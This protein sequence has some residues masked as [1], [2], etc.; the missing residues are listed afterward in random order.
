MQIPGAAAHYLCETGYRTRVLSSPPKTRQT[1]RARIACSMNAI[2]FLLGASLAL[3]QSTSSTPAAPGVSPVYST[4]TVI[5]VHSDLVLIPVTVTDHRGKTVSGLEKENFKLFE[6]DAEQEIIHFAS[7][8]APA[9]IGI[10][11][12]TSGSMRSKMSKAVDAV[13]RLLAN[14][15]PDDEFFLVQFSTEARL[16]A[17][18]TTR[19]DDIR[20]HMNGLRTTG[21]TALLDA[22]R[23]ALTEME[24]AQHQRKAIVIISDGDDNSSSWTVPELKTAVRS[25]DTVIYA[26]GIPGLP[27]ERSECIPGH[28]C[29]A[30][31]LREISRQTGG[32]M[33]EL[34]RVEQLPEIAATIGGWLRHQYVLGYV[35]RRAERDGSYRSVQLKIDRPKGYPKFSAVW[36]QGYYAPK[37]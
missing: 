2:P 37:E 22:V 35:P 21:T 5:L 20:R 12:D 16:V 33:F 19:L 29:G 24:H 8:S 3:A 15:N 14:A 13:D 1:F 36:R 6:N 30:G 4:D 17:P 11:L 25:H 7:E 18:L 26:I 27:N 10:V 31:L 9:S 28:P 32:R 23:T 34:N